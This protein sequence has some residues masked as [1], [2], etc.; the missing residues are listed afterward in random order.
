MEWACDHCREVQ[1]TT[2]TM[3][4]EKK[5]CI[6][7]YHILKGT[8]YPYAKA[9]DINAGDYV[10]LIADPTFRGKV[11]SKNLSEPF[12]GH[13]YIEIEKTGQEVR[14]DPTKWRKY[15]PT[16]EH[17][18]NIVNVAHYSGWAVDEFIEAQGLGFRL[19]NVVKY[20]ARAGKKDQTKEIEDL[21]KARAYLSREILRRRLKAGLPE[22]PEKK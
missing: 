4:E 21:E 19:G 3:F 15:D 18:S 2:G 14:G 5:V 13:L 11:K 17:R 1:T 20:V 12:L 16:T 6:S 22:E 10:E 9:T 8:T 7:C